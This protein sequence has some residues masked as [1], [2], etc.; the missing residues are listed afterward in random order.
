MNGIVTLTASDSSRVVVEATW[1]GCNVARISL[2]RTSE[3]EALILA[4]CWANQLI[5][6]HVVARIAR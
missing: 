5:D 2:T 3:S 6:G 4:D 1:D